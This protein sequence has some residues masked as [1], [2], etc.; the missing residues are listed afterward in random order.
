[1]RE[2]ALIEARLTR[3]ITAT[4]SLDAV[5]FEPAFRGHGALEATSGDLAV[6]NR[7][8]EIKCVD[9]PYRSTDLRQ[10]LIYC[11]L[12]FFAEGKSFEVME[13]YNPLKGTS[14]ANRVDEIV[15]SASGKTKKRG[16]FP[17][18]LVCLEHG[19]DS[20][21]LNALLQ[22]VGLA[23]WIYGHTAF[24][25]ATVRPAA[26]AKPLLR[27]VL[28]SARSVPPSGSCAGPAVALPGVPRRSARGS[29]TFSSFATR[30]SWPRG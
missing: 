12:E 5:T 20:V 22:A 21:G 25:D 7:I 14:S 30:R 9:R 3:F 19:G 13:L 28:A 23:M 11:A 10:L 18:P 24:L 29:A 15:L 27:T 17:R 26:V 6:P 2:V 1:M 4:Y 8:I 16:L